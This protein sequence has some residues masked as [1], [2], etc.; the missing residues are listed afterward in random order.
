MIFLQKLVF[1]TSY[2][3]LLINRRK[4]I[5]ISDH[6]NPLKI[7]VTSRGLK[8]NEDNILFIHNVNMF[9]IMTFQISLYWGIAVFC[10]I[11]SNQF[12]TELSFKYV[13]ILARSYLYIRQI[14]VFEIWILVSILHAFQFIF[15]SLIIDWEGG[16]ISS[17]CQP[18]I[19]KFTLPIF[20]AVLLISK[21]LY[22]LKI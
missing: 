12:Q 17:D 5:V 10:K 2:R 3:V 1:Q 11:I 18:K 4:K 21:M 15:S 19:F 8:I 13:S 7:T 22:M 14:L 16:L 9:T 20:F 6:Q